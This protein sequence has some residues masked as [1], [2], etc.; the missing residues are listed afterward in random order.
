M[1]RVNIADYAATVEP[2]PEFFEDWY[3]LADKL[4]GVV[5]LTRE[6]GLVITLPDGSE[7]ADRVA[8][9]ITNKMFPHCYVVAG[10]DSVLVPGL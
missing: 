2:M 1:S 8:A 5:G 7:R 3:A 10:T 4:G 9:T 6:G